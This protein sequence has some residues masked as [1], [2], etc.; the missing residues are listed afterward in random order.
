MQ[1]SWL[2]RLS[3]NSRKLQYPDK[4]QGLRAN[5]QGTPT[6]TLGALL[7]LPSS[8][9]CGMRAWGLS[10]TRT[11]ARTLV[12]L[13]ACTHRHGTTTT[14]VRPRSSEPAVSPC[15]AFRAVGTKIVLRSLIVP[16][17]SLFF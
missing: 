6:P 15:L 14:R 2:C 11:H 8:P 10:G 3:L 17:I 7:A 4:E 13:H 5:A 12:R 9:P 16:S 1:L